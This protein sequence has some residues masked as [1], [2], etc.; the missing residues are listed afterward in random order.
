M[1]KR[2]IGFQ[3]HFFGELGSGYA[4]RPPAKERIISLFGAV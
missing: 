4:I 1:S 3:V 2:F